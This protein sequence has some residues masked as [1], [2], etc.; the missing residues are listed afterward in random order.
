MLENLRKRPWPTRVAVGSALFMI[1]VGLTVLVGWFSH[2]PALIQF[3]LQLPPMTRNAAA[4]SLLCG[5]ASLIVVLRGPRWLAVV[6]AGIVST[7]CIL[8]LVEFVLGVN[9]GIDDLLGASYIPIRM[10]S[11]G[12]MAP[13]AAICFSLGSISLMLVPRM[14]SK[15][16]ELL[17]ALSGS[18]IAAAGIATVMAFALGSSDAF[19]W[20]HDTRASLPAA[21]ALWIFGVGILA[22]AWRVETNRIGAPPWLPISVAI[23][24]GTTAIAVWQALIADGYSPFALVPAVVLGGGCLMAPIFGLTIYQTQRAHAQAAALRRG[25][26]SE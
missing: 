5:L 7:V 6:C 1:A 26:R 2:T 4:C 14:L 9:V 18:I 24:V 21:V 3:G 11:P 22:L 17:L 8:T 16:H 15:R 23:G 12:R 20:G 19:G 25:E 10:S 13:V